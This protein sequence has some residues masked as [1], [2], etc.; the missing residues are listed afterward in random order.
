MVAQAGLHH[1]EGFEN[2]ALFLCFGLPF[3][4]IRHDNGAFREG[5]SMKENLK[6]PAFRFSAE[7]NFF[8]E[9]GAFRKRGHGDNHVNSLAEFSSKTNLK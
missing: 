7:K 9:N 1:A 6:A 3:T 5:S 2:A 8:L 4:L